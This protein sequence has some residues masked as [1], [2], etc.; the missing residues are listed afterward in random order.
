MFAN[1][2]DIRSRLGTPLWF[3]ENAVPRY[4]EFHPNW[5]ANIY[6]T[7]AALFV[8]RCQTCSM[9]YIVAAS[10]QRTVIETMIGKRELHFGDPPNVGCGDASSMRS[11][12]TSVLQFWRKMPFP[13]GWERDTSLEV[14]I[15]PDWVLQTDRR[16]QAPS[17]RP[18]NS[19]CG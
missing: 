1:Y 12:P 16:S 15:R 13:N 11:M 7:E 4:R 5:L 14:D 10:N 8:V 3:D 19:E 6:A 9:E 17:S 18:P 2:Y